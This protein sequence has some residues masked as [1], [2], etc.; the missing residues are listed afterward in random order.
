[1][2]DFIPA[3]CF[4]SSTPALH[5]KRGYLWDKATRYPMNWVTKAETQVQGE[6]RGRYPMNWVTGL[7]NRYFQYLQNEQAGNQNRGMGAYVSP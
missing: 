6:S 5:G 2:S 3:F 4:Y 7:Q 1:M